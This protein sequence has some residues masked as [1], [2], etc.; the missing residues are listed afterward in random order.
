MLILPQ[1]CFIHIPKSG[2]SW[3][4][5]AIIES[6]MV[7]QDY[8]INGNGHVELKDCPCQEKFKF[9][10]VRHPLNLYRSY[11]QFKMTCGWDENNPFDK[12]CRSDNFH[13]FISNLLLKFPGAYSE[14]VLNFVGEGDNE[15]EFIGKYENLVDDLICALTIAGESFDEQFIRQY[16]PY[17]VSDK[18]NYSASYTDKLEAE[19]RI[20]DAAIFQRFN[21]T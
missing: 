13:T 17:N 19:I 12:E 4:K 15:I 11:W 14:W 10:F 9:A 21:Y 18:I 2:G 8:S 1:S 6:N 3:V 5:K 16:P 20:A 7:C